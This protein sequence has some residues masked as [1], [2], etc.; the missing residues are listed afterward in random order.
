MVVKFG[1]WRIEPYGNN[2]RMCWQVFKKGTKTAVCYPD[3]LERAMRWCVEWEF[4]NG[5][6]G[7]TVGLEEAIERH[8][9]MLEDAVE[10]VRAAYGGL[11]AKNA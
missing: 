2:G 11:S 1:S 5:C 4:R 8:G 7:E 6:P 9:A 10:A 3:T